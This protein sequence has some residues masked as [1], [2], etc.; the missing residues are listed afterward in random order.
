[1]F[2]FLFLCFLS[3]LFCFYSEYKSVILINQT[4]KN[5]E[6]MKCRN[7]AVARKRM[8]NWVSILKQIAIHLV[9]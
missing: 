1:M 9:S 3:I 8:R 5:F 7:R 4:N 6:L 2:E